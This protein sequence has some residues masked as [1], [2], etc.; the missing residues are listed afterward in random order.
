MS[1]SA[2]HNNTPLN[3]NHLFDSYTKPKSVSTGKNTGETSTSNLPNLFLVLSVLLFVGA[4][5][6]SLTRTQTSTDTRASTQMSGNALAGRLAAKVAGYSAL[7]QLSSYPTSFNGERIPQELYV[8]AEKTYQN[9]PDQKIV[10]T[11]ITETVAK[12]YLFRKALNDK[13][14]PTNVSND[15]PEDFNLVEKAVPELEKKVKENV[16]D[17]IDFAYIKGNLS[18]D[19]NDNKDKIKNEFGNTLQDKVNEKI[20]QYQNLLKETPDYESV[21]TQANS[22]S[23]LKL[24]NNYEPNSVIKNYIKDDD[25]IRN[26]LNFKFKDNG[27]HNF[28]FSQTQNQVSE[29]YQMGDENKKYL[30]M[31]VLPIALRD[32]QYDSFNEFYQA[33]LN[34]FNK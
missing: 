26:N 2:R 13:N 7:E 25:F 11:Y 32:N 15:P 16:I 21:L 23:E 33:N 17:S 1:P 12:F 6:F 20:T 18:I 14:V 34:L 30:N 31:V 4:F 22:D 24:I 27:F 28:L 5:S 8:S 29:I 9:L 19:H 3:L 10:K